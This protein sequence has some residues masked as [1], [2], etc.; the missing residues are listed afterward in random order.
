VY[1]RR[2]PTLAHVLKIL[3]ASSPILLQKIY[4]ALRAHFLEMQPQ[5]V[6]QFCAMLQAAQERLKKCTQCFYWQ[7]VTAGCVFCS[8][9]RRDQAIVCVVETW[10][11]ILR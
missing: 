9:S 5:Q 10:Q 6:A 4:I 3:Q 7:E 1:V 11:E 8:S 2:L